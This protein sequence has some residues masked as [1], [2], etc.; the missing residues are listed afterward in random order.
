MT[1]DV[2]ICVTLNKQQAHSS[3]IRFSL[4]ESREQVKK[5]RLLSFPLPNICVVIKFVIEVKPISTILEQQM[6]RPAKSH[7]FFIAFRAIAATLVYMY[8]KK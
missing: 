7:F 8:C 1:K 2:F 4:K 3:L 6:L 5:K